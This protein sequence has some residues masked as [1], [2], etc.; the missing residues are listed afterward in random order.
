MRILIFVCLW[1]LHLCN[2]KNLHGPFLIP[3][4][5]HYMDSNRK[6][7]QCSSSTQWLQCQLRYCSE[8]LHSSCQRIQEEILHPDWEIVSQY[9]THLLQYL[10][11]YSFTLISDSCHFTLISS[12]KA[13]IYL[14]RPKSGKLRS[15]SD[16]CTT[17]WLW[18]I[19]HARL[20]VWLWFLFF[21][22]GLVKM[23]V[24]KMSCIC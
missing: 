16:F 10:L 18:N 12:E 20:L 6:H 3:F 19:L 9:I 5:L 23:L 2:N 4:R 1:S 14:F 7:N 8:L 13:W 21:S 17:Y 15:P 24:H 11:Y 22:Q